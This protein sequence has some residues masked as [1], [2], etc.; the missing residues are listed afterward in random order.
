MWMP[1]SGIRFDL[2]RQSPY[3]ADSNYYVQQMYGM[4][5][6]TDVLNL[7]NGRKTRDGAGQPLCIGS[8]GCSYGEK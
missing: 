2:V 8:A 5:A 4:N 3:D 6:G 1:G 7:Q